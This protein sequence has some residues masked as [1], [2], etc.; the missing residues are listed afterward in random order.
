MS[1]GDGSR[2]TL[3][4]AGLRIVVSGP[5]AVVSAFVRFCAGF[6]PSRTPGSPT[7][8][9]GSFEVLPSS[10]PV[11]ETRAEIAASFPECPR[12]LLDRANRLTSASQLSGSD[13]VRRAWT[14]GLWAKAVLLER[15]PSPN[16]TPP[17]DLRSCFYAVAR[18]EGLAGPIIF[19]SS[20]S[21]WS[22]VGSLGGGSSVS[23]SFPSE[24]EAIVYLVAAGFEEEDIWVLP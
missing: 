2:V 6:L 3:D 7:A 4:L 11:L 12:S 9:T 24:T 17:L 21:Y 22:A 20:T 15:V 19:K 10:A 18:C 14:A 13:R 8:S 16:R 1:H 23:Q 5:F